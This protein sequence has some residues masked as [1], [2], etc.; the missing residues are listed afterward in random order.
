M[1]W[2]RRALLGVLFASIAVLVLVAFLAVADALPFYEALGR[3]AMVA[4]RGV[5]LPPP[6]ADE[7]IVVV[8][9]DTRRIPRA[10]ALLAER[11][12]PLLVISG[13]QPGVTLHQLLGASAF[14]P[15][16]L[17]ERIVIEAEAASTRDNAGRTRP[18]LKERHV[19]R[20]ILV[21]SDYHMYRTLRA[22]ESIAKDFEYVPYPVSSETGDRFLRDGLFSDAF[23]RLSN[24]FL[25]LILYKYVWRFQG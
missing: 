15:K 10:L 1:S 24:E 17:L 13:V 18:L 21:T 12:A 5:E 8:T 6:V 22:F 20:V 7:A 16:A 11:D 19:R 3:N 23:P 25:K 9:G 4:R 2:R 14:L